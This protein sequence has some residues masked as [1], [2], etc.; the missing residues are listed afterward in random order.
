MSVCQIC[1]ISPAKTSYDIPESPS[2]TV[3]DIC[4]RCAKALDAPLERADHWR[5]K[6]DGIWSQ[7]S[8]V[9]VMFD[10]IYR[11]FASESW[12]VTARESLYLSPEDQAWAD[13][14]DLVPPPPDTITIDANGATLSAGDT[15][16]LIKDLPVK[17]AGFTA[18]RGTTVRDISLTPNPLHVE[19]RVK[20][21]RIVLVAA[22]LK[23]S[24]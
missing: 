15:V 12:A 8:G 17:G 6:Y 18:K 23:K 7:V 3:L 11:A 4:H 13:A 20:G 5:A 10:R 1:E 24:N 9:N 14:D 22:F 19:G 16:T 21:Q 2:P